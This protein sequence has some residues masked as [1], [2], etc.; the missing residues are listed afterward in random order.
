MTNE[1]R[2]NEIIGMMQSFPEEKYFKKDLLPQ[3]FALQ[4][5]IINA[6]FNGEHAEKGKLKLWDVENHLEKLNEECCHIA[7]KE[8]S[9]F[10]ES[11]KA[12]CN[13]IKAETS[14]AAGEIKAFHS[15]ERIRC[16]NKVLQN[17]DITILCIFSKDV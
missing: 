9:V 12:I 2:V 11:S 4:A 10:K 17:I 3:Y 15:L 7:D 8:F 5:E 16:K 14:G 13:A 1:A 6:T